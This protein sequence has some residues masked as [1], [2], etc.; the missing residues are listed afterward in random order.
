MQKIFNEK[1]CV[2]NLSV[3]YDKCQWM[4]VCDD[5]DKKDRKISSKECD[6]LKP[7]IWWFYI[8]IIKN[9]VE[10]SNEKKVQTER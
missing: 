4:A 1:I 6:F 10:L 5:Q 9:E 3:T 8:Y 7:R 2:K